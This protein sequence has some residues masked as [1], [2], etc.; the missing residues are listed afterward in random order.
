M[1]TETTQAA[2]PQ[3][4][5]AES[6][7][8]AQAEAPKETAGQVEQPEAPKAEDGDKPNPTPKGVQKR[9]DELRRQAGDAQRMNERLLALMEKTLTRGEV[10]KVEVSGPPKREDFESYEAYLEAKADFRIAE[11]LKNLESKVEQVRQQEAVLRRE[12][13]WEQRQQQAAKKYE[14]FADVALADDL[15]IT[16]VMAE[17]MKDSDLGPDVAYYLGKNPDEAER[18]AKLNPA[19]QV[20]EIGKIEARLELKPTKQPSKAPPPIEPLG[21][22]KGGSEPDLSR[23]SQ[24]EYEA[25]RK[26]WASRF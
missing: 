15:A 12:Q 1:T 7:S 10:P 11:Q 24:A 16:P 4:T 3:D 13:T 20:R 21:G 14:D 6:A 5:S 17:A 22:G 25:H 18:I 26:K 9:L 2:S 8:A 19:A 23:M